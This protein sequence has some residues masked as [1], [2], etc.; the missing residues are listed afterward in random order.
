MRIRPVS[1]AELGEMA[2]I[3]RSAGLAFHAVG[4]SEIADDEPPGPAELD[5]FRRAG[6]AWVAVDGADRPMAYL[7]AEPVDGNL[8]IE[9]VSV[10]ADAA[11]RG[12][13]R[14]L[15]DHAG[16]HAARLGLA[17]LTLTTFG[18]VPWNAPY[19][20][21]LGFR[22]MREDELTPGLREIRRR[23]ADH[24]LDRWPRECMIRPV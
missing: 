2:D 11:G 8:H 20:R 17:A 23:E 10:H 13:G 22:T 18:A 1:E 4:M 21:R 16:A 19:Y 14:S 6:L 5:G 15:I 9:Q 24:G 7:V 12:W 3:E